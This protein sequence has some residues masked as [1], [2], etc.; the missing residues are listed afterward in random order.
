VI[1]AAELGTRVRTA[2][3]DAWEVHGRLRAGTRRL[4]GIRLAA[5]GLPHPQHNNGDVTAPDADVEGARAFFAAHGADWGVRVPAGMPWRHGRHLFTLRLMGLAPPAF[6]PTPAV[7]GIGLRA[8]D[9]AD[10]DAVAG[11]GL[12]AADAAD[13]DAVAGIG[14]RA[15]DAADLDAVAAID[16]A[17][18]GGDRAAS[19]AWIAGHLGT[20]PVTSALAVDDAG[21]PVATGYALRS[22]GDAGPCLYVAGVAVLPAARGRG[23]GAHLTSWLMRKGFAAGA[24]LAHLHAD[25]DAAA[26]LYDR[27]GFTEVPGLEIYVDL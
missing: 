23:V 18:F 25:T 16:A 19:R 7:A 13:L 27:L 12:R 6:R 24:T 11:I 21:V 3:A 22:D 5:S 14:L 26:R 8:A 10:L 15:A 20:P 4:H 9:A 2:H 1:A 17:V